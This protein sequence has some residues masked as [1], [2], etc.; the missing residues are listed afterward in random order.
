VAE[1]SKADLLRFHP[2]HVWDP[3]PPWVLDRLDQEHLIEL[4]KVHADLQVNVLERQLEA[5]KRSAE[6]LKKAG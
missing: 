6:I 2:E 1:R 4:A 3:A 5:A